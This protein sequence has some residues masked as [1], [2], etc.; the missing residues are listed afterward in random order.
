MKTF[1]LFIN[2]AVPKIKLCIQ[3][4]SNL[5]KVK[6]LGLDIHLAA[7]ACHHYQRFYCVFLLVLVVPVCCFFISQPSVNPNSFSRHLACSTSDKRRHP[8]KS[9]KCICSKIPKA[10]QSAYISSAQ[11]DPTLFFAYKIPYIGHHIY[12]LSAITL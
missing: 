8:Y 11:I 4:A 12:L 10:I 6:I 2:R 1:L 9:T 5:R 3:T 7:K